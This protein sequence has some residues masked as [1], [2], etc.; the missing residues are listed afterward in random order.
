MKHIKA[1]VLEEVGKLKIRERK[2][3][4]CNK[5]EVI[6]KVEACA[7]CRTDLKCVKLG[8]RDL[9]LP[10]VLGHELVGTIATIGDDVKGYS[11]G[12][13]VQVFPGISCGV[14]DFCKRGLD[15]LCQDLKIIGFN[16]DGGFQEYLRIPDIGVKNGVLQKLSDDTS[17]EEGTV[18]E[19]LACSINMQDSLQLKEAKTM[20][21]FGAGRLGFLNLRLARANGIEK[22]IAV[23]NN[24]TRASMAE[25]FGFDYV[26]NPLKK[27][28]LSEVNAITGNK[29]V[30][31]V[32][33]CCPDPLAFNKGFELLAKRGQYGFFSG[34]I[35]NDESK[36][37]INQIHYKEIALVGAYGCN[38][39]SNKKAL[40]YIAEK[41]IQVRDLITKR[42]DLSEIEA[43]INLIDHDLNQLIIV[44]EY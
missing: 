15:N 33:N 29:G 30:D 32:I 19:P 24:E 26:I 43:G 31:I 18:A 11:V 21:I 39:N 23:E 17:F 38:S 4:L 6:V 37:N 10:R 8:Q 9:V 13:R 25:K 41:K 35:M 27:D 5:G 22:I 1:A 28:V 44:V 42:I 36:I 16:Y 14:C 7:I 34:L 20:L 40:R 3:L 12:E 2:E